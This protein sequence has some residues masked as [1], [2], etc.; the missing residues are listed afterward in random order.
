LSYFS[1]QGHFGG[2]P[3][4]RRALNPQLYF[5]APQQDDR[6]EDGCR[7]MNMNINIQK[8]VEF[9]KIITDIDTDATILAG[10]ASSS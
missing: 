6:M 4:P 8:C 7:C 3:R 1:L 5:L 10:L 2:T 9:V